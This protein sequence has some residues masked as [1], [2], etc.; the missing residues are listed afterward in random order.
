MQTHSQLTQAAGK[1][2]GRAEGKKE[3]TGK[4]LSSQQ[5]PCP[6][7]GSPATSILACHRAGSEPRARSPWLEE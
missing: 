3:G 1:H 4:E 6:D 7:L 5:M 2:K